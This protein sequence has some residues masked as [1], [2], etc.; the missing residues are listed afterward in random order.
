MICDVLGCIEVFGEQCWGHH[1]CGAGVGEPFSGGAIFREISGGFEG[2]DACEVLDGVGVFSVGESTKNDGAG[3]P[4]IL[5]GEG[6]EGL[7]DRLDE[8]GF[9]WGGE[10]A[11]FFRGHLAEGDLFEDVFPD[12]RLL[13][14]DG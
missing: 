13:A 2:W 5:C 10:L 11:F 9:F 3:I 12:F 1:E 4:C 6:V 7:L 8:G 14:D